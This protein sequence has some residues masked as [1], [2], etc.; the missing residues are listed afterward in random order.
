MDERIAKL[1]KA[2]REV[3]DHMK[4]GH[5]AHYM[6][7]MGRFNPTSYWCVWNM[8]GKRTRQVEKLI[9][10]GLVQITERDHL[11]RPEQ[12]EIS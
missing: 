7:Y 5:K 9:E 3:Y 1:T 10:L 12:A 8:Q 2:Q 6:P 4:E 11:G